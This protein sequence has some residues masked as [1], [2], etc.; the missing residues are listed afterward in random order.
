MTTMMERGIYPNN[1]HKFN[2]LSHL[3][4]WNIDIK[5]KCVLVI[6]KPPLHQGL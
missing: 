5:T 2:E 3:G 6:S 4:K 1:K